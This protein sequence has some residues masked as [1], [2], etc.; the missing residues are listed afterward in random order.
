MNNRCD[1]CGALEG[2]KRPI[3]R[4]IVELHT[5]EYEGENLTFCIT[6]YKDYVRKV[7]KKATKEIKQRSKFSF[8]FKKVV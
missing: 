1:D 6:C 4:Y 2:H 8:G 5:L 3:G 7:A